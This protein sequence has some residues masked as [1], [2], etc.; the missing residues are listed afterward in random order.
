MIATIVSKASVALADRPLEQLEHDIWQGAANL[1][2]HEN[3][4]VSIRID[5]ETDAGVA[6]LAA[7]EQFLAADDKASKPGFPGETL[8]ARR[9]DAFVALVESASAIPEDQPIHDRYLVSVHVGDGR[10]E[11]TTGSE[12][13]DPI[14][15]TAE[16]A[17]RLTCDATLQFVAEDE[18]GTPKKLSRRQRVARGRLRRALRLRDGGCRFPGCSHRGRIAMH[19][20]VH[21]TNEGATEL[22][23]L[24]SLCRKHHRA[25][26]E[27][28]WSI[29]AVDGELHFQN[30]KGKQVAATPPRCSGDAAWVEAR[31]RTAK[32]GRCEWRGD[33]LD[34]GLAV[35][36]LCEAVSPSA[37]PRKSEVGARG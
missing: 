21:Y 11:I 5:L 23:N 16:A 32:Q 1:K 31:G 35:S 8:A 25:V 12:S 9:A 34:L 15:I 7:I 24:L 20:I 19:H 29:V 30:P 22:S 3:G 26:H 37:L 14:G 10:C 33:Q 28:G 2:V 17:R 6:A 4:G 27:G 18:Q 36:I 13:I